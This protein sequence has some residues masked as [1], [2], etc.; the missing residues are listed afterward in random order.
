M[1]VAS[2]RSDTTGNTG[3]SGNAGWPRR[4]EIENDGLWMFAYDE[5]NEPLLREG[6]ALELL[7]GRYD[8]DRS[9]AEAELLRDDRIV[10]WDLRNGE[11][12]EGGPR[13]IDIN[14]VDSSWPGDSPSL[15]YKWHAP[16]VARLSLPSGR[17]RIHSLRTC[18]LGGRPSAQG[19]TLE[20]PPG[21]YALVL[22]RLAWE[23]MD[24]PDERN[25]VPREAP[26]ERIILRPIAGATLPERPRVALT[27]NDL[28]ESPDSLRRSAIRDGG[29]DAEVLGREPDAI[30]TTASALLMARLGVSFG[31]RLRVETASWSRDAIYLGRWGRHLETIFDAWQF[32][33]RFADAAPSLATLDPRGQSGVHGNLRL[34]KWI[35]FDRASAAAIPEAAAGAPI[36]IV[37]LPGPPAITMDTAVG[38]FRVSGG[39]LRTRVLLCGPHGL[40]LDGNDDAL[41]ALGAASSWE[42]SI[43]GATRRVVRRPR[44]L[45]PCPR[46][47]PAEEEA[48]DALS[49][50]PGARN[51]LAAQG[52]SDEVRADW[53][54]ELTERRHPLVDGAK[55]LLLRA[56]RFGD[57]LT[58]IDVAPGTE[59][60][61]RQARL[62][63]PK[64]PRPTAKR[65]DDPLGVLQDVARGLDQA[66]RQPPAKG[67]VTIFDT[68]TRALDQV[69]RAAIPTTTPS[70]PPPPAAAPAPDATARSSAQSRDAAARSRAQS[71]DAVARFIV[72][73]HQA[74]LGRP[75]DALFLERWTRRGIEL[76]RNANLLSTA[77]F[78]KSEMER[79]PEFARLQS[80]PPRATPPT[81]AAQA[82]ATS[83]APP[84]P[85]QRPGRAE[86]QEDLVRFINGAYSVTHHRFPDAGF[87]DSWLRRAMPL[88]EAGMSLSVVKQILGQEMRASP[89]LAP[90]AP[91]PPGAAPPPSPPRNESPGASPTPAADGRRLNIRKR[92]E[93]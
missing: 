22:R 64:A 88:W 6:R 80:P 68:A 48:L 1:S 39:V 67:L 72:N 52:A 50:S 41:A 66:W 89:N 83:P 13:T 70:R 84:R 60:E 40:V 91:P 29:I 62:E 46:H 34:T 30:E 58:F 69:V 42:L 2:T 90:P 36:R 71:R 37:P 44:P 35:P 28:L 82:P 75:P 20:V 26:T 31:Q 53:P 74:A 19:A 3:G 4:F 77:H 79:T 76:S 14:L 65:P 55:V 86:V 57:R 78:L 16:Q 17:L 85:Q 38:S 9:A 25:G 81:P 93:P 27:L 54:L 56:V 87:V 45:A 61:L 73:H 5:A 23:A 63:L 33:S 12:R 18:P 47:T 24:L 15:Q 8:G 49:T 10:A 21:E 11:L 7:T 92:E 43:G 59:V 32:W 51:E